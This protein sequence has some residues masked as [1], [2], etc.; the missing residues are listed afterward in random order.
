MVDFYN[1]GTDTPGTHTGVLYYN[2]DTKSWRV[3]HIHGEVNDDDFISLQG[4]NKKY[5]VTAIAD[6]SNITLTEQV[7]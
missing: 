1:M 6:A 4:G 5:G 3:N 2:P 7:K